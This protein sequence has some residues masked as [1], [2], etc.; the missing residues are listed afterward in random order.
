MTT[1]TKPKRLTS[2]S[3]TIVDELGSLAGRELSKR[4]WAVLRAIAAGHSNKVIAGR[5]GITENTVKT[6][7]RRLMAKLGAENRSHAV[8]LGFQGGAL[9]TGEPPGRDDPFM[10]CLPTGVLNLEHEPLSGGNWVVSWRAA[11]EPSTRIHVFTRSDGVPRGSAGDVLTWAH[12]QTW[13][14]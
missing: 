12:T 8:G 10:V 14:Q 9:S 3:T 1:L 7:V 13:L 11:D 2:A 5:L 4:E 6:H